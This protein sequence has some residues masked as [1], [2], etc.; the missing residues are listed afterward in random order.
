MLNALTAAIPTFGAGRV[1][2]GTLWILCSVLPVFQI[3]KFST[4]IYSEKNIGSFLQTRI[5]LF[6]SATMNILAVYESWNFLQFY[7]F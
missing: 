1:T 2:G 3:S 4:S 5:T 7:L 6:N